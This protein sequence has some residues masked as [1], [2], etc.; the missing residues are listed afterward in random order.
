MGCTLSSESEPHNEHVEDLTIVRLN[1]AQKELVRK[2]W[3]AVQSDATKAGVI[4]FVRLF[5]IHPECKDAFF[6]FRDVADLEIQASRELRAHGLRVLS[7]LEKS[8]A[9]LGKP[10]H[11]DEL[12][13]ELG[14]KHYHYNS[15]PK[16]YMYLGT[17]F[18]RVIKPILKERW[19]SELENAWMTLFL[20]LTQMMKV[21]FEEEARKQCHTAALA[22]ETQRLGDREVL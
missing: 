2:S 8:V 21:G 22:L 15:N 9:R 11:L 5:E 12:I 16:Y 10:E 14:R 6:D 17:E 4:M 3:R 7:F 20:Y 13:L 19:S 18:I 1:E